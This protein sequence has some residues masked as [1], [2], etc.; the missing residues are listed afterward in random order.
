M[1]DKPQC[2]FYSKHNCAPITICNRL[3]IKEYDY[4]GMDKLLTKKSV[5]VC[6]THRRSTNKRVLD[7]TTPNILYKCNICGTTDD[8]IGNCCIKCIDNYY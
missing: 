5:S 3:Y 7:D 2:N 8:L 1:K 4:I 6:A